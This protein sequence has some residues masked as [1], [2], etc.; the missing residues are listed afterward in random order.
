MFGDLVNVSIGGMLRLLSMHRQTG[1]LKVRGENGEGE[2]FLE[3]GLLVGTDKPKADFYPEAIRLL[4]LKKGFFNFETL[5]SIPTKNRQ[6]QAFMVED[7]ILESARQI[8]PTEAQDYMPSEETVL[9]LAPVSGDR[10]RVR[11][12][13]LRDEWNM[14]TR[15]NGEDSLG[16]VMEKSELEKGRAIQIMYGLLSAGVVRKIRYKIPRVMEIATQEL[17]NMGEALVRQAFRK[18]RI[19][20]SRMH[21]KELIALLNELERNITLL[22]GPTRAGHIIGLMWEGSKR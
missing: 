14:L 20:Q 22:M 15:I 2:L 11:L 19:D 18:L 12:D 10:E 9:Q 8:D 7:L 17:G 13:L 21:M 5:E 16:L 6:K 4:L 3:E 1:R